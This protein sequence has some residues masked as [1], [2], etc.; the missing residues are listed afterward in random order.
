MRY[1]RSRPYSV[2]SLTVADR[3]ETD[4][5]QCYPAALLQLGAGSRYRALPQRVAAAT[6]DSN[7]TALGFVTVFRMSMSDGSTFVRP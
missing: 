3:A 2:L 1:G 4:N 7:G 6:S 5:G